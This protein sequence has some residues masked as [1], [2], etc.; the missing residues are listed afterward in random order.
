MQGPLGKGLGLDTTTNGLHLAFA[1][2]TGMLVF[3]D[4]VAR[5]VLSTLEIIPKE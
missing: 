5:L 1:A 3:M 4:L 2:G